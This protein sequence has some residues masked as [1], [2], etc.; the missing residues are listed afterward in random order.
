MFQKLQAEHGSKE[1]KLIDEAQPHRKNLKTSMNLS[2]SLVKFSIRSILDTECSSGDHELCL[3]QLQWHTEEKFTNI[4]RGRI[5]PAMLTNLFK[6][7]KDKKTTEVL[8]TR[9]PRRRTCDSSNDSFQY[10]LFW[11][12]SQSQSECSQASK[13]LESSHCLTT[14]FQD[15]VI[16]KSDNVFTDWVRRTDGMTQVVSSVAPIVNGLSDHVEFV[17]NGAGIKNPLAYAT[18]MERE[19]LSHLYGKQIGQHEYL[20]KAC[21]K[22]FPLFRLLT[23]HVKCHSQTR[24]YLCSYCLKGFNDT[25]D[26]KRHTRTHTGVRPY[27]CPECHKAFTQRCSLESH[28]K[29]VHGQPLPYAF[30]ERRA[31]VYICEDCGY[32]TPYVEQFWEHTY[33][34][35]VH[36]KL[37]SVPCVNESFSRPVT[38]EVPSPIDQMRL[39]STLTFPANYLPSQL[40]GLS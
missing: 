19:V 38:S 20:C 33:L 14:Q 21:G 28:C 15:N 17:N 3:S 36:R 10:G 29:K 32:N 39:C 13:Q 24:R 34:P 9:L 23:R 37:W 1:G 22:R 26:L 40:Y 27:K 7:D 8:R 16:E 4:C 25:F 30:K 6:R 35:E 31:K 11:N 2:D 5:T 12:T 18:K